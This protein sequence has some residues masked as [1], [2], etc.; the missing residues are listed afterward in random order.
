MKKST[1]AWIAGTTV[2]L[3]MAGGGMAAA[4]TKDVTLDVD[5]Q[6]QSVST[7][8]GTVQDVLEKQKITVSDRDVVIPAADT[9]LVDGA[10]IAVHF[11]RQITLTLDG[12]THT[13]WTTATTVADALAEFGVHDARAVVSV[14]RSTPLGREGLTLSAQTA[15]TVTLVADGATRQVTTTGITVADLLAEQAVTLD[16]DDRIS[17]APDTALTDGLTLTV[18]RVQVSSTDA[19]VVIGF[20]TVRTE[21]DALAKGVTRTKTKGVQ[22]TKTQTWQIVTV[23]GVEESRT[24]ISEA[25][26]K[27]AVNAEV[28]VG[29][30]AAAAPAPAAATGGSGG[31]LDLSRAAMWDRIAQCESGG[32]WNIN[33]GNGYYG[34]L[35]FN[36]ATW[37]S[38][39]GTDFAA[40]PHQATREEQITVANRLYAKRGLQ[41]W[42]CAHAA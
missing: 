39:G 21:T 41:P 38:V 8:A 4:A 19:K 16:G 11:A 31:A 12:Q 35:Q 33:T 15:K 3:T 28:L 6:I 13:F 23:D 20:E 32:R 14:D 5:G 40:L 27:A 2:A 24:L 10:A 34:G 42:G 9:R 22:G 25:V 17:S 18:Q 29:T 1:I 30:A 37:R 36:A 7:M 26:T